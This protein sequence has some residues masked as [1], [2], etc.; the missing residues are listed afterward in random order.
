MWCAASSFDK[1][2]MRFIGQ[3][4]NKLNLML[5]LSKHE[6]EETLDLAVF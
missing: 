2:R 5:S 6:N 1:L 4:P 3:L